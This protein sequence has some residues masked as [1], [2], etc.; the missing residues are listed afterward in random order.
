MALPSISFVLKSSSENAV[1]SLLRFFLVILSL[2]KF[3]MH[4]ERI[5][6]TY[7]LPVA[8]ISPTEE[9]VNSICGLTLSVVVSNNSRDKLIN[10]IKT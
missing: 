6:A 2:A 9:D 3:F 5:G 1:L 8:G 10:D 4:F 7:I